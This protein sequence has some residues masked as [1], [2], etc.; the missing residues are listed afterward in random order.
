M[1]KLLLDLL[2]SHDSRRK[3]PARQAPGG[4]PRGFREGRLGRRGQREGV[5]RSVRAACA[6]AARTLPPTSAVVRPYPDGPPGVSWGDS[7]PD[8]SR[9]PRN[10]TMAQAPTSVWQE[11]ATPAQRDDLARLA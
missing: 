5:G 8:P 9:G 3:D 1:G 10:G 6:G 4:G 2:R 7:P 11:L